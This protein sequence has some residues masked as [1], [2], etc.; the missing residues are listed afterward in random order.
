M[1]FITNAAFIEAPTTALKI[2]YS[3]EK[4]GLPIC[5]LINLVLWIE[6]P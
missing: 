3:A 2:N 6:T 1:E 5:N 4:I